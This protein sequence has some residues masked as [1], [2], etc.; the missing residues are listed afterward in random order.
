MARWFTIP[1]ALV[2]ALLPLGC[3]ALQD[4][5]LTHIQRN[6][7]RLQSYQGVLVEK[8]LI[9]EGELTSDIA[10]RRPG[11]LVSRVTSPELYKGT[12]LLASGDSLLLYWP[13]VGYV[14]RVDHLPHLD[15]ADYKQLVTD[16]Y[17]YGVGA[18]DG[19]LGD[20]SHVAGHAT[21]AVSYVAKATDNPNR[22]SSY[23]VYDK[24]SLP[25]SGEIHFAGKVDY[26]FRYDSI[27]FNQPLDDSLFSM[28]VP[29]STI[30]TH[31]DL[32][33]PN[34][35]VEQAKEQANFPL[36][37]PA[38]LPEGYALQRLVRVDG[39]VP[40]FTFVYRKG[41]T[42]CSSRSTRTSAFGW[43]PRSLGCRCRRAATRASCCP[44][45]SRAATSTARRES[46]FRS[47]ATSPSRRSSRPRGVSRQ[48]GTIGSIVKR[49]S[50]WRVSQS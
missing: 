22:K 17:W 42:I 41:S 3:L 44:A 26:G 21:N 7:G 30:V 2:V 12:T 1:F 36:V 38:A 35:T 13:Q 43:P 9:P 28:A 31:W 27:A 49:G 25:L 34:L 23:Q 45:R 19:D 16:A 18:Y 46:L 6:Q 4:A 39:P 37:V 11:E 20:S 14:I 24:F 8:G 33:G 5:I 32:D 15:S 10:F 29:P 47:S 50:A 40:A 48:Q